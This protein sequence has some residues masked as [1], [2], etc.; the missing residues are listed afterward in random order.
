M[1]FSTFKKTFGNPPKLMTSAQPTVLV[2]PT[3]VGGVQILWGNGGPSTLPHTH[4]GAWSSYEWC[5]TFVNTSP[6]VAR[7]VHFGFYYLDESLHPIAK[8]TF[9]R[10]GTFGQG[11]RIEGRSGTISA[12]YSDGCLD[13]PVNQPEAFAAVAMMVEA[14]DYADGTT[15]TR[16]AP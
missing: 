10:Y 5:V 7:R 11:A 14:V 1:D 8:D 9:A 12:Q 6:H 16:S 15:F 4:A 13:P 3:T 2:D